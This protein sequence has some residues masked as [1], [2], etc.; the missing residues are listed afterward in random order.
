MFAKVD[1]Y[2]SYSKAYSNMP[3][4][5]LDYSRLSNLNQYNEFQN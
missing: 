1:H 3:S 2:L 4:T 5:D